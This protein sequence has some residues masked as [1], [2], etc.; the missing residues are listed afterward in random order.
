MISRR[1]HQKVRKVNP[2]GKLEEYLNNPLPF[3]VGVRSEARTTRGR[4]PGTQ[5]AGED[6]VRSLRDWEEIKRPTA[7]RWFRFIGGKEGVEG[8]T[9]VPFQEGV[10]AKQRGNLR[11]LLY[12]RSA[13][14]HYI[15]G[16]GWK[17][18]GCHGNVAQRRSHE[19]RE[20][21]RARSR[22]E[23]RGMPQKLYYILNFNGRKFTKN[24]PT[25]LSLLLTHSAPRHNGNESPF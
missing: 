2:Y 16:K 15:A 25:R 10:N 11:F 21:A 24:Q 7:G 23:C 13:I 18:E 14:L 5:R 4:A 1:S 17:P 22:G 8:N 9:F 19:H 12:S 6:G 3:K 20:A